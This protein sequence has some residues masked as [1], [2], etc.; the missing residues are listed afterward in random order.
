MNAQA[1]IFESLFNMVT[2]R[3]RS[4]GTIFQDR[5]K[6]VLRQR[7]IEHWARLPKPYLLVVPTQTRA[8]IN[9]EIDQMSFV[10]PRV[11]TLVAQFDGEGS[12]AEYRAANAIETAEKQLIYVLAN[13]PPPSDESPISSYWPTLYG[14]MRLIETREPDVKA[15]YFFVFQ[16]QFV[17]KEEFMAEPLQTLELQAMAVHVND[18]CCA[19]CEPECEPAGPSI[20]VTGGG[21]PIPTP[22]DPC[23][24][25]DCPPIL[26]GK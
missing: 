7:D 2:R 12:E 6:L 13:W 21:C 19:P 14:G 24:E 16:E 9:V 5:V 8:P 11:V 20:C 4:A 26:E 25:P 3:I 18:P 15:H 23:A 10:N 22:E 1:P 17:I